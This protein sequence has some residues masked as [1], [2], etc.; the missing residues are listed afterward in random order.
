MQWMKT[1]DLYIKIMGG[2]RL[3]E[4][5][6]PP[7]P[8]PPVTKIVN[9]NTIW[10]EGAKLWAGKVKQRDQELHIEQARDAAMLQKGT[11]KLNSGGATCTM[12]P[13]TTVIQII[14]GQMT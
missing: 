12:T 7:S 1:Y 6:R 8:P 14:A 4:A 3:R 5:A 2:Q 13:Q 11:T 9:R 10:M